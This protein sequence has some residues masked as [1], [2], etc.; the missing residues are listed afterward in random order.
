MANNNNI[1]GTISTTNSQ[2]LAAGLNIPSN[3][4]NSRKAGELEILF[5]QSGNAS[6]I[7]NKYAFK[8]I[9]GNQKPFINLTVGTTQN[10]IQLGIQDIQLVTKFT[11]S[12][13]GIRFLTNQL[14]LQGLNTFNETK[15]YN[16]AMP[17]L[18][19]TSMT[20]FGL[21]DY[22]TR[23]IEPNL[24]GIFGTL[25]LSGISSTVAGVLG[26]GTKPTPP[27]GTVAGGSGIGGL[28][29]SFT[30]G[31][32]NSSKYPQLPSTAQDGGK[33]LIRGV[34]ATNA[35][36]NFKTKWGGP[37]KGN[38]GGLIES[39]GNFIKANTLIGTF[40]P[41]GQPD[42]TYYKVGDLLAYG[43][44]FNNST[45]LLFAKALKN[46]DGFSWREST[47][48]KFDQWYNAGIEIDGDPIRYSTENKDY[49]YLADIQVNYITAVSAS[50]FNENSTNHY[51]EEI[52]KNLNSLLNGVDNSI[53]KSSGYTIQKEMYVAESYKELM[54][55]KDGQFGFGTGNVGKNFEAYTNR[56]TNTLKINKGID[57]NIPD[58]I[59]LKGIINKLTG[60]SSSNP[61]DYNPYVDD[62]IAFYFH[63]MVNDK[64]IPFRAT[65]KGIQ[66]SL[67]ADWN[68]VKYINRADKLYSYGGFNRTLN[69]TFTV[70]I[71]SIKELLPTWKRINYFAGLVKPANYTD[72]NIYSRFAIPPLIN[73]TVGDMYKNQP[74]VITQIGISI[75]DDANWE[76]L[77]E[78][79]AKDYNWFYGEH[80]SIKR[81]VWDNSKNKYAQFP[82][83]CDISVNMNLLEKELS[84]TGG[85]NYGDYYLDS[86][87]NLPLGLSGKNSF[88]KNMYTDVVDIPILDLKV[89]SN[90][91]SG[92]EPSD[93]I[94]STSSPLGWTS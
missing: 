43:T 63:D 91:R 12:N 39:A 21:L 94:K 41:V 54:G 87:Q 22:P 23:F 73:F 82:N 90:P 42:G 18:A 51:T 49:S 60:F 78:N 48:E 4:N 25:G 20:S 36:Q 57:T 1:N 17:I 66:E 5:N 89:N 61:D 8:T 34:T 67:Q 16:P 53:D 30:S 13:A 19:A 26:I 80:K 65:I 9:S 45:N 83:Q 62:L 32:G 33:G 50:N 64:Y 55:A 81:I 72:G 52:R 69:F 11:T 6:K 58:S 76:T 28:I 59:N 3:F 88:S 79:T 29:S 38:L 56:K 93:L 2:I 77:S 35:Y 71:T 84:H 68:E 44:I 37:S 92:Y 24:G 31:F 46:S 14:L 47:T 70:V 7:Y 86:E 10:N 85:A 40:I 15:I 27:T 74:A 75:P